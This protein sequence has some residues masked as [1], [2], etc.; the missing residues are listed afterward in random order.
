MYYLVIFMEGRMSR[1]KDILFQIKLLEDIYFL[2]KKVF[3]LY[4]L[5]KIR[6]KN[7]DN[8]I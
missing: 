1:L 7:N 5:M 2:Y 4:F 6:K 8:Q 3:I